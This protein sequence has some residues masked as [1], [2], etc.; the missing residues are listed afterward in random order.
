MKLFSWKKYF[1]KIVFEKSLFQFQRISH[2]EEF[3]HKIIFVKKK[4]YGDF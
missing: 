2:L 3:F 1:R 4:I